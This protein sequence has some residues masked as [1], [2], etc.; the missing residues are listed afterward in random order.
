LTIDPEAKAEADRLQDQVMGQI[1]ASGKPQEKEGKENQDSRERREQREK[2]WMNQRVE[3]IYAKMWSYIQTY[4]YSI[5]Q[6]DGQPTSQ[7][8]WYI[9]DEVGSAICHSSNP[10][11][12]VLP[13]IFSRGASGMIPYSVF[14]PIKDIAAGEII[15]CDLLPKN[16]ERE[17]DK[18]AY[19]FAFEDRVLLDSDIQSKRRDLVNFFKAEYDKL[20]SAKFTPPAGKVLSAEEGL[21]ALKKD[22]Q[23]VAKKESVVV[24]TDTSFVQQFLKLDNVKFTDNPAL[25]DIIWT[26]NDFQGWDSLESHQTINQFPNENCITYKHN[27]AELIQ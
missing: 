11:V 5:L 17:S 10:N 27:M 15:T 26:R 7:T 8:A 2:D 1:L 20:K 12:A 19:L 3:N 22:G 23:N 25:A 13:F 4:S 18:L 6:Q 9:T 21:E 14:F 16:L 24:C